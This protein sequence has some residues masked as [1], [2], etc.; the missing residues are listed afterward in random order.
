[1]CVLGEVNHFTLSKVIILS[2][3]EFLDR[4]LLLCLA[5]IVEHLLHALLN[6]IEVSGV[7][8]ICKYLTAVQIIHELF[9]KCCVDPFFLIDLDKLAVLDEAL[10]GR[11]GRVPRPIVILFLCLLGNLL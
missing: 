5:V 8:V 9:D 11:L 4:L 7:Q 10:T 6:Q 1:M 2:R 3:E